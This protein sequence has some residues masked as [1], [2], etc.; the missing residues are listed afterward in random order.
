MNSTAGK[1]QKSPFPISLLCNLSLKI[2]K[3]TFVIIKKNKDI[4]NNWGIIAKA[5]NWINVIMARAI[6]IILETFLVLKSM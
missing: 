1:I 5:L 6:D 4:A 3:I 2:G